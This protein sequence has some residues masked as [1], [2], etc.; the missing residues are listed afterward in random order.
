MSKTCFVI[1]GYGVKK[2]INLDATYQEIIKPCIT[3]NGLVP[4][5]LFEDEKFNAFRCDEISGSA[6]IDY[7]FVT[8]LSEADIV[9][10]DI[11][12]MNINAIYELGARHALK[13]WSTILLCAEDKKQRFN[14]FD[15]TYVPIIFYAHGG[16]QL[17]KT[18]I[19]ETKRKLNKR[20]DFAIHSSDSVPD[21]PIQRALCE[22]KH[23]CHPR[24]TP[25]S[26]S[27][28]QLYSQGIQFLNDNKFA[29]AIA[30]LTQL[31]KQESSEENL[32][33]MVLARYKLAES[34]EDR[35]EL[36]ECLNLIHKGADI[37]HSV[38]ETL[39]GRLAAI[40]LR[41]YNL[42]QN[43]EYY[44]ASLEYYRRG[45][46]Y[47]RLDLYC[48]R[49]Y[50]ALLLRI[51]EI[52][53]DINILREHYYTAKHHA[54]QYLQLS[55]SAKKD[56][57]DEDRTYYYY[58]CCDLKAIIDGTYTNYSSLLDRVKSD[59][60]ITLR[61]QATIAAGIEKLHGDIEEMNSRAK[62]Y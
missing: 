16:L 39:F 3:E 10:A 53:D 9:I 8:C 5:P 4:F 31:Y 6:S 7:Q 45:S 38:S 17:D 40:N 42:T 13:P 55:V 57:S 11:S 59:K 56:G 34:S 12:T 28:F 60:Y 19:E 46:N 14:F 43:E 50:C 24:C 22:R 33:L 35:S 32:L 52:T 49:N 27:I 41:L 21:N 30:P 48:P 44:Y 61:Q 54:K 37:E 20:L 18:A 25:P 51:Y 26:S 62:L 15:L 29:E 36:V 1:M 23:L 47:S 58:N 2:N